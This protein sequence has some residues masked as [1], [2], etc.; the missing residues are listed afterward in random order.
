MGKHKLGEM[1]QRETLASRALFGPPYLL[2]MSA[3]DEKLGF[4]KGFTSTHYEHP[5][6]IHLSRFALICQ[7]RGLSNEQI[8]A[9]V[10]LYYQKGR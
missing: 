3:L 8:V 10:K 9:I 4:P 1:S 5:D 7:E 6:K 2:K